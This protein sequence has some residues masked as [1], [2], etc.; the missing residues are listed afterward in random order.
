MPYSIEKAPDEPIVVV[1]HESRQLLAEMGQLMDEIKPLLDS[2]PEPVFLVMD[3]RRLGIA[4]EDLA[5]AASAAAR[6]PGALLHHPNV[7]ENLL[8]S[9]AGLVRLGAQGLRTATFGNTKVRVFDTTEQALG[10]CR[11]QIAQAAPGM[12]AGQES[13]EG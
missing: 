5:S 1:V 7:R 13:A 2:Q 3:I 9:S 10:Y 6:G 4:V 8:V 11:D 12:S